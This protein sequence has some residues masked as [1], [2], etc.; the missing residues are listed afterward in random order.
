M[1]RII[2]K[3][4]GRVV[5][6]E[7]VNHCIVLVGHTV[8]IEYSVHK[9]NSVYI[10]NGDSFYIVCI[11]VHNACIVVRCGLVFG[12]ASG[13]GLLGK[14]FCTFLKSFC[15]YRHSFDN[16][17]LGVLGEGKYG[18]GVPARAVWPG[19]ALAVSLIN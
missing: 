13:L 5:W 18:A 2:R 7:E 16:I 15:T 8:H 9:S 14:G 19:A 10:H 3:G 1:R 4:S 11:I 6:V 17:S 12:H